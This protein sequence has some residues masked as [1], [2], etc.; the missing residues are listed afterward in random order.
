[1]SSVNPMTPGLAKAAKENNIYIVVDNIPFSSLPF[2]SLLSYTEKIYQQE[3]FFESTFERSIEGEILH[4]PMGIMRNNDPLT[5]NT[6]EVE[7]LLYLTSIM[8]SSD[9]RCPPR[10]AAYTNL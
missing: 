2:I 4:C 9:T 10:A 3:I 1:M 6:M 7:G 8:D 5:V